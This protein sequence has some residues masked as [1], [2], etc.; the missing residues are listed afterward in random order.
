MTEE[1]LLILVKDAFAQ[2]A[3]LYDATE[4]RI[5]MNA[6][7]ALLMG[8]TQMAWVIAQNLEIGPHDYMEFG[9]KL[10]KL[11]REVIKEFPDE[12]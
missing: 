8:I 10:N 12:H 7:G 2:A 1:E 9:L 4:I 11:F 5:G 3:A 6:R